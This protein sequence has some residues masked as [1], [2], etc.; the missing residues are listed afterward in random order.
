MKPSR[1]TPLFAPRS[2]PPPETAAAVSFEF[3]FDSHYDVLGVPSNATGEQIDN[4]KFTQRNFYD[5]AA[6]NG[7]DP[8]AAHK[9]V[10]VT[11]AQ[12]VLTKPEKRK[13]YDRRPETMFLC[14]QEPFEDQ[15]IDWEGGLALLGE[16]LLGDVVDPFASIEIDAPERPNPL[17]DRYLGQELP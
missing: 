1:L 12:E 10:L 3:E 9:L 15:P 17:V 5:G 13:E 2:G 4:A 8:R 11:T 14:I 16:L 6:R 7:S